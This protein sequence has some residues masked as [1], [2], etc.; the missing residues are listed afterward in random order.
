MLWDAKTL[1]DAHNS[2]VER[3][4]SMKAMVVSLLSSDSFAYRIKSEN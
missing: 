3:S 4:G 2:Y 1:H